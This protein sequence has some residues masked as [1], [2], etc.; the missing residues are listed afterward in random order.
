MTIEEHLREQFAASAEAL[1][2]PPRR[3]VTEVAAR[4]G[5]RRF[6][7]W[8]GGAGVAVAAGVGA[9]ALWASLSPT[10]EPPTIDPAVPG[11]TAPTQLP[12]AP[13]SLPTAP[14]AGSTSGLSGVPRTT[15]DGELIWSTGDEI[16]RRVAGEDE[17]LFPTPELALPVRNVMPDGSGGALFENP[18]GFLGDHDILRIDAEGRF[19]TFYEADAI[20]ASLV[21][22]AV[23]EGRPTAFVTVRTGDSEDQVE[24]VHAVDIETGASRVA[25]AATG[26]I[27]N[28]LASVDARG[29]DLLVTWVGDG[30]NEEVRLHR[31]G[32]QEYEVLASGDGSSDLADAQ[33]I[34]D[35]RIAWVSTTPWGLPERTLELTMHDFAMDR[36]ASSGVAIE[37]DVTFNY[38]SLSVRPDTAL[39]SALVSDEAGNEEPTTLV[40]A[41]SPAGSDGLGAS[42]L[43]RLAPPGIYRFDLA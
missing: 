21:G 15:I 31:G 6:R 13:T 20:D 30:S 25:L 17:Q 26:G 43:R 33:F 32:G 38:L 4:A 22:V 10:P 24:D 9:V 23:W 35:D 7:A 5:R 8:L 34:D 27:E 41:L 1:A 2:A 39:I 16:Y 36:S 28:G 19:S 3:S 11:T 40:W 37:T 29:D 14:T 42:N 18:R 12:T